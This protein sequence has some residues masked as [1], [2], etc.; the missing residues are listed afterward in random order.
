MNCFEVALL[1]AVGDDANGSTGRSYQEW[2]DF[3]L[4]SYLTIIFNKVAEAAVHVKA[5]TDTQ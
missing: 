2:H 4:N 1:P 3:N 5:L